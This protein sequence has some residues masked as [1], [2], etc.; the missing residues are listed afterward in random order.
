MD[1]PDPLNAREIVLALLD[2]AP[3]QTLH[4]RSVVQKLC[5]FAGVAL[6]EDLGHIPQYYGPYS[7]DVEE[8]LEIA[9]LAGQVEEKVVRIVDGGRD[10]REHNYR[11]TD[12]GREFVTTL[13]ARHPWAFDQVQHVL[14]DVQQT[15]PGM[16]ARSLSQAAKVH[17]ILTTTSASPAPEAVPAVASR[18]G[19]ALTDEDIRVTRDLLKRFSASVSR[20]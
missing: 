4:G 10:I 8:G 17:Q 14:R 5:Y 6:R 20:E 3:D 15:V 1:K 19:W 9:T 16:S 12:D 2:G 13:R 7:R 18:L 11:L